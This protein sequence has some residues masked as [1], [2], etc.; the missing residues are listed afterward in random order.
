MTNII[1]S[2]LE[3][4]A[5]LVKERMP[6]KI[7]EAKAREVAEKLRQFMAK[8]KLTQAD[9]ARKLG[10]SSTRIS[11]FLAGKYKGNLGEIVNKVIN[12]INSMSRRE[13]RSH[14]TGYI[15]TTVAKRISALI[16]Q[17][18]AYTDDEGTI[19]LIIGDAGHGKSLCL[20]Q[21]AEA[22]H[23]TVYVELDDAM[24]STLMFSAIALELHMDATG[25][26]AQ[27]T[28]QLIENLQNR[29]IIIMLDE[30]SGLRVRQLNQL[31]Q[32]IVTK[33][34]CPLILAGNRHLLD[35]VMQPTTRRGCEALDQFASRLMQVLDLDVAATTKGGGGGIYSADDI[36]KLYEYG[37]LRLTGDAVV[38]L[39]KIAETPKSGRLRTCSKIIMA[40]HRS[41]QVLRVGLIDKNFIEVI[42]EEL[43]LPVHV[44]LHL[45]GEKEEVVETAEK[46]V[47]G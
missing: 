33:A 41:S 39:Q 19:G 14:G 6:K 30:A 31:R 42:I 17:C 18:E 2:D 10:F 16:A 1:E 12:F 38:T 3:M 32:I 36:R 29:H 26:L 13:R 9:I 4:E 22:N 23:N 40:L 43:Q 28:R 34:R 15:E 37:Q 35:T 44:R 7:D 8:R 46:K 45:P 24:T 20:R 27:V 21:Y 47:A 5:R 25:S 11:Q